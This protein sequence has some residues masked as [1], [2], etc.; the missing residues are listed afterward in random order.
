MSYIYTLYKSAPIICSGD[1]GKDEDE[2]K[3]AKQ[4]ILSLPCELAHEIQW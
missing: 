3:A 2:G 1:K 4:N